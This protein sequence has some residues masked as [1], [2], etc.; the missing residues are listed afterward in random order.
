MGL[1]QPSKQ[2]NVT[3]KKEDKPEKSTTEEKEETVEV[4]Q[5]YFVVPVL[6]VQ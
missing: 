6:L 1:F 2:E 5:P 4:R 3:S